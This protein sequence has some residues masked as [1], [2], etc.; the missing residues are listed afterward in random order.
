MNKK[1]QI[2]LKFILPVMGL[3][4]IV[5][6]SFS[7]KERVMYFL[8]IN[9]N[10]EAIRLHE[11][12]YFDDK[13]VQKLCYAV[14]TGN[15][16]KLEKLLIEGVDINAIGKTNFNPL[17]W[18]FLTQGESP[19]KRKIFKYLVENGGNATHPIRENKRTLLHYLAEYED[20][21][22]LKTVLENGVDD[23]D[24]EIDR[25]KTSYSTA[26][27]QADL[28][29]RNENFKLL[30]EYGASV[31][32][33]DRSGKTLLNSVTYNGNWQFTLF[34]LEY[35]ADYMERLD[36]EKGRKA[37]G[38]SDL[39]WKLETNEY[40]PSYGFTAEPDYRQ[41]VVEFLREKGVEVDPWMPEDEEYRYEEGV[42]V[43]YIKEEN[44]EWIK[45]KDSDR[46]DPN[47]FDPD[48]QNPL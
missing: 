40:T 21:W 1:K 4:V 16:R 42:A 12:N 3:L 47:N 39:V 27:L 2:L 30:L 7:L 6:G 5:F 28:A 45:F 22:Y 18:L 32:K 31:E 10:E 9:F 17:A 11:S 15:I 44:G 26:L 36:R 46:Y 24:V 48:K 25:K 37:K 43:L 20:P 34:L 33:K 38:K 8:E 19:Q 35:G 41:K 14:K 13:K 23:I 29:G